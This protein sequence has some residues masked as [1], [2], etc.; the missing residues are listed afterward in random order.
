M[1]STMRIYLAITYYILHCY[2]IDNRELVSDD[3]RV[4]P[5]IAG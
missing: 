2:Y 1:A 5:R 4:D 3:S